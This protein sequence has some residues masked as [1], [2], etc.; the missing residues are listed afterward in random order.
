MK[1]KRTSINHNIIQIRYGT[2]FV[3]KIV[4]LAGGGGEAE[5][6]DLQNGGGLGTCAIAFKQDE[7]LLIGGLGGYGIHGKVDRSKNVKSLKI[8]HVHYVP[9]MT[10]KENTW[11]HFIILRHHDFATLV[12]SLSLPKESRLSPCHT[13]LSHVFQTG[14]TGC[15]R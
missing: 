4:I 5:E 11:V 15:W 9:G 7:F 13:I 2:G 6:F 12:Q 8:A 3:L 1:H 10:L 14:C